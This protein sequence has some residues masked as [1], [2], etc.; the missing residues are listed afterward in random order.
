MRTLFDVPLRAHFE[1]KEFPGRVRGVKARG[2]HLRLSD[3]WAGHSG[4]VYRSRWCILIGGPSVARPAILM[5]PLR[6]PYDCKKVP[7]RVF[8]RVQITCAE[9]FCGCVHGQAASG[10]CFDRDDAFGWAS[11]PWR[12]RCCTR[13]LTYRCEHFWVRSDLRTRLGVTEARA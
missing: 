4:L 9:I 3:A 6:T 10:S 7:R 12:A 2:T 1:L 8:G 11:G 13:C 5:V